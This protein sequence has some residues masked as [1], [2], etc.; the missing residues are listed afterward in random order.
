[1]ARSPAGQYSAAGEASCHPCPPG[2]YSPAPGLADQSP[3]DDGAP[4]CLLCPAGSVALVQDLG[5]TT[6]TAQ[7]TAGAT[8]CEAW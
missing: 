7:L 3:G 5:Q 8:V 6:A 2:Q 4:K 1:M